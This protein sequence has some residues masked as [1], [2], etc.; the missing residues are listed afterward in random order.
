MRQPASA[1]PAR[2]RKLF[3][4]TQPT[5]GTAEIRRARSL[6]PQDIGAFGI[7]QAAGSVTDVSYPLQESKHRMGVAVSKEIIPRWEWRTFGQNFGEAERHFAA[8]TPSDVQESDELYFLSAAADENVKVRDD[9]MDIKALQQVNADGLEQWKPVMKG[10]FP[11][12]VVEVVKVFFALKIDSPTVARQS[13]SLEQFTQELV[14]PSGEVRAVKVHKKRSRY[15]IDGCMAEMA[16]VTAEGETIRTVALE[17]EDP[18][19]VIATV[20]K[21]GLGGFENINYPRGLKQLVGMSR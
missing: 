5:I 4:R 18:A 20:R 2:R 17:L 1:N 21:I 15:T 16:E 8:L 11:L 6:F 13:Y 19:H 12:P 14:E 10:T 3:R 7:S 9:L